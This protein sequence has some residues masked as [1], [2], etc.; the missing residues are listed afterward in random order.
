MAIN[1]KEILATGL[2]ELVENNLLDSITIKQLLNY[3]GVSRQ[4]FYNHFLDKN[5]LIQYIYITKIIPDYHDDNMNMNFKE[6]LIVS[7][8]NMKKYHKFLKEA[9]MYDGQN[10]LKDYICEHCKEFDLKWHQSLYGDKPMSDALRFATIYH[11]SASSA[12]SLS[13]ILSDMPVSCEEMADMITRMRGI[14]MDKLFEDGDNKNPYH[15]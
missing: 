6:S 15:I 4:T 14:G 13:W 5:D 9:C 8:Q 10:N 12:M 7:F 3:T 1:V 2:L 11:A